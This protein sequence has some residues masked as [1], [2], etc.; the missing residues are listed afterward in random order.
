MNLGKFSSSALV[1]L[2]EEI[3]HQAYASFSAWF[4]SWEGKNNLCGTETL[5][6]F[7]IV[8]HSKLFLSVHAAD[9]NPHLAECILGNV[10]MYL[11]FLSFLYAEIAQVVKTLYCERHE[12]S[13]RTKVIPW[14]Q[15]SQCFNAKWVTSTSTYLNES[16]PS[17]YMYPDVTIP[18]AVNYTEVE[19]RRAPF[20]RRHFQ[21]DFLEWKCMDL[22]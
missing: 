22:D 1:L 12:S 3:Y 7:H 6:S 13:Y 11:Q 20:S 16:W 21:I 14:L 17:W 4:Y 5:I 10:A 8:N 18:Q 15:M 19:T 9:P 2:H